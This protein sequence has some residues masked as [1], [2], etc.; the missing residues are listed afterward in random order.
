MVTLYGFTVF[1]LSTEIYGV[2]LCFQ[3]EYGK[4]RT[5]RNS[6]LGHFSRSV[7]KKQQRQRCIQDSHKH[8]R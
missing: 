1:E 6:V 3:S 4:I 2:N 8:P 7:L 5:R